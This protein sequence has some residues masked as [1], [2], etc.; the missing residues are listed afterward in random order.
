MDK[1]DLNVM[2]E[3]YGYLFEVE[4]YLRKFIEHNMELKYG[5]NWEVIAH[6]LY[7]NSLTNKQVNDLY[8]HELLAYISLFNCL[9]ILMPPKVFVQLKS[10]KT[11]RNKIAHNYWLDKGEV[12]T[13][14]N[15]YQDIIGR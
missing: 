14:Y 4:N 11:I 7:N 3:S 6:K 5:T 13:L 10:I 9:N 12:I 8:Y 15:I 1:V 2:K